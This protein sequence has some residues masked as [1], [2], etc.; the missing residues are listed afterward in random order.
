MF[1]IGRRH[2]SDPAGEPMVI[3]WR[4]P[5]SRPFYRASRTEP[6]G[7]T[8]R[9]RYGFQQGRLTAYEDEH[10]T[11][12]EA[13]EHSAILETEIERPRVGP[14]RDIVATIQPEQDVIVRSELSQTI[15]VQGA[16]GTGKTAVGLHRAAYLLYA[17]REQL[18]RRGV[19]VVG[20]NASFLR[21]I[22][23]V[24][25][26][27]GEIDAKQTTI[28]E[29]V[30][31]TLA[32]LQ[33]RNGIRGEDTAAVATLKGDARMAAVLDRAL[34][35]HVAA[36][37]RGSGRSAR[38]RAGGG[39]RRTRS[40]RSSPP[41]GTE[42]C[43]TAPRGRCCPSPLPTGSC[44]RWSSPAMPRTTG[45]RT[46]SPAAN[47]SRTTSTRSGQPSTHPGCCG[48]CCPN[49]P[50]WR[51]PPTGSSTPPSRALCSGRGRRA[52]RAP[53]AGRSQTRCCWMRPPT[54]CSAR[55]RSHT[56]WRTRPRTCH[57]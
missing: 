14:M 37:D 48:V 38:R 52:R 28:V 15:C 45:S 4:A 35:S 8:L 13:E 21:F 39:S 47:R 11:A 27:L 10:L 44:S 34:W 6:M 55:H 22:R 26:A 25:P 17:Y 51:M 40:T 5:V 23:D 41:S 9:R 3:D 20:P 12:G 16:P 7:V 57:R 53:P 46:P 31:D 56:S 49:R 19:L 2:V 54:W 32:R 24:L 33:P 42:A 1:H 43:G 18:S 30:A 36:P 29:L 50:F